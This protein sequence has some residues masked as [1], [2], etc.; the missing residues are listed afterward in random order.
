MVNNFAS[1][2]DIARFNTTAFFDQL[3]VVCNKKNEH[4][5][6]S[7][8]NYSGFDISTEF[9]S[10]SEFDEVITLLGLLHTPIEIFQNE[11]DFLDY[12][13][14]N[15][16]SLK[17]VL[18][19]N[20]AQS[21]IGPG[22]KSLV[23]AFCNMKRI[24][25]TGS[26]AYVVSLCRHK[27]HVNKLLSFAGHQ[28]PLSWLYDENGWLE[29]PPEINKKVI[30][31]PIYESA[32]IGI[33]DHAVFFYTAKSDEE[34]FKKHKE[35]KQPILVQEFITGYEVEYPFLCF[36]GYPIPL[37]PIG[38][39]LDNENQAMGNNILTYEKVYFDK[40]RFYDFSSNTQTDTR[41][42]RDAAHAVRILGLNG[43]C[44][45]DFRVS[46]NGEPY[47]TDVSANP[48]FVTHSSV[49]FAIKQM[50][51]DVDFI[52]RSIVASAN[53]LGLV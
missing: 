12:V 3:F 52:P 53:F 10:D 33:D 41:I 35:L 19:Y 18:V 32:S 44:R 51:F 13:I 24:P 40:Y 30:V 8:F 11:T 49:H 42:A 29:G 31:K 21:G 1:L 6:T 22:R 43:L 46:E 39:S 34:I 45:V 16:K 47:I 9:L 7:S 2:D 28:V 38:I 26:N 4:Q 37:L 25:Y 23:P 20:S 50:G 5:S 14:H 27:Y 17:K 48:H 15:T 36:R